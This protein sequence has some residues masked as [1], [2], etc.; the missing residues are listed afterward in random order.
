VPK[1]RKS[2]ADKF[3]LYLMTNG[4]IL[5]GEEKND[6]ICNDLLDVDWLEIQVNNYFNV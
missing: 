4:E 5:Y 3:Y 6:Q 1:V 2:M